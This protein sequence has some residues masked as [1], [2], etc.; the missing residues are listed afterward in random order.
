MLQNENA[1]PELFQIIIDELS[2]FSAFIVF[3]VL[4]FS[5]VTDDGTVTV[6]TLLKC[7]PIISLGVY[8]ISKG[9]KWT[10]EYNY[11]QRILGGLVFSC[12]G[13]A[14]LNCDMFPQG[15]A[16]FGIAQVFYISAFELKPWKVHVGLPLYATATGMTV[17]IYGS[18]SFIIKIGLPVYAFLLTTMCW[19][20]VVR[21]VEKKD[22]LSC[23][24]AVGSVLFVI[25]DTLISLTMFVQVIPHARILVMLTY[26]S[27]QF[28]IS[29]STLCDVLKYKKAKG[30]KKLSRKLRDQDLKN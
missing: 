4:Y 12:L 26:Y 7:A 21:A 14:L 30:S 13:D 28:C 6:T 15:M 18:L 25:S 24:A 5:F 29:L 8:V 23:A 20:A 10:K 22:I 19:R 16:V 2:K 3:L 17:F 9:I 11:S 27:A 1:V